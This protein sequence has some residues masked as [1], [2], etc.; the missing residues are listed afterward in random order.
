M[1]AV[2][3]ELP[4]C[5]IYLSASADQA[6]EE[7]CRGL[8]LADRELVILGDALREHVNALAVDIGSRT[9][10]NPNSLVRDRVAACRRARGE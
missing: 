10:S 9:P 8:C 7:P 5:G 2:V 1:L 4:G 3:G 6:R